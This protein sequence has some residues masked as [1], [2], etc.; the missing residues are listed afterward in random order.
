VATG[1]AVVSRTESLVFAP[2]TGIATA[3][4]VL[5][6]RPLMTASAT[7]VSSATAVLVPL[8]FFSATVTASASGQVYIPVVEAQI[9]ATAVSAA[10]STTLRLAPV[11]TVATASAVATAT[12]QISR[13]E[14]VPSFSSNATA[15]AT[16]SFTVAPRLTL[17]PFHAT[18]TGSW[19]FAPFGVTTEI[20][21]APITNK[22]STITGPPEALFAW[23]A[24]VNFEEYVVKAVPASESTHFQ[25]APIPTAHGSVNMASVAGGFPAN[26][27]VNSKV[28]VLDLDAASPG[29]GRKIVKVYVRNAAGEWST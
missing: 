15:S 9:V 27:V 25:G 4:G 14:P 8:L 7:A 19:V 20:V 24:G 29:D 17:N 26:T 21:V 16:F 22:V 28:N 11:I 12:G 5:K 13:R 23:V 6:V 10:L 3:S 2:G 1:T 18:A